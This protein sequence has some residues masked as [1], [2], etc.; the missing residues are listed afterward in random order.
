MA[1]VPTDDRRVTITLDESG[2]T[3]SVC[4]RRHRSGDRHVDRLR[5]R[6]RPGTDR[7][8]AT[9]HGLPRASWRA[10][11]PI[12]AGLSS[13][14]A[15]EMAVGARAARD[16]T[17]ASPPSTGPSPASTS[18]NG[19]RRR[20]I[21]ASWTRSRRRLASPGTR[22][23]IDCRSL[24]WRPVPLPIDE[25]AIVVC[26]SGS[27][28]RLDTSAYNA[29]RAECDRAVAEIA[30]I[31][32]RVTSLRDVDPRA[33]GRG[34]AAHGSG[35]GT[36]GSARRRRERAGAGDGGAPSPPATWPRSAGSSR[37]VT[38][39][40][41]TC[42]RSARPSS[43]R[44]SRS[45]TSTDGV[46]AA[47][48]TGAGFGGSTVNLVRRDQ[49]G[50]FREA[51]E[52][53]YPP[54]TGLV[55]T[56]LE[57]DAVDGAG[58]MRRLTSG[59]RRRPG[60]AMQWTHPRGRRLYSVMPL[61]SIADDLGPALDG[62]NDALEWHHLETVASRRVARAP[63][64]GGGMRTWGGRFSGETDARVADFTRSIEIDAA[65]AA[66][67]IAGSIA[68]VR[69]LGRAGILTRRGD[70]DP[71]RWAGRAGR[72]R[73]GGPADV[74]P[75]ARRRPH[76]RRSGAGREGRAAGRST[77]HGSLAQRPGRHRPAAVDAPVDRRPRRRAARL[78]AGARR[79]RR[80]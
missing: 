52:R 69:G 61:E 66:D 17:R 62:A 46:V 49:V 33:A 40:C 32:P 45:P 56:V 11:L 64:D 42:S 36:A 12:A 48:M 47:R 31:E 74:G 7:E 10:T 5:G 60:R 21:R 54:R 1:V 72:R 6:D 29:R 79:P 23:C 18:E 51:I 3:A 25:V 2:E 65:L 71:R 16:R 27:S 24:E 38:P 20:R 58:F 57:V 43:T 8:R 26:H 78:R 4:A 14:A 44:W 70:A 53:D 28:R 34:G 75:D 13:S 37:R 73:R 19:L 77:P 68:H 76:E 59:S 9:D 30:A 15:L 63:H 41:G 55:P 35:R 67:D 80:A 50:A 22:S 39:R